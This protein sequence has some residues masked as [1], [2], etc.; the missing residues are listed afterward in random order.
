MMTH[1][2]PMLWGGLVVGYVCTLR[3]QPPPNS[4]RARPP[5]A[6]STRRLPPAVHGAQAPPRAGAPAAHAC[7]APQARR[8]RALGAPLCLTTSLTRSPACA[9]QRVN[10]PL[11][12]VSSVDSPQP[13]PAGAGPPAPA[14]RRPLRPS[15]PA[16]FARGRPRPRGRDPL[17]GPCR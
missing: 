2:P 17:C 1:Q 9:R 13:A 12:C 10:T 16:P 8:A 6:A 7:C 14:P 5:G 11:C 3:P 4:E 15:L